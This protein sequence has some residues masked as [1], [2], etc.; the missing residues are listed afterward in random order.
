MKT[1]ITILF[2]G[3]IMVSC[4]QKDP[5]SVEAVIESGDLSAMKAKK[6]QVLKSYDSIA[7]VLGRLEKAITEKDTLKKYPLV[8]TFTL[9]DTLFQHFIDI[10]GNVETDQNL[11]IYPEYQGVLTRV[12]VNE[13]DKVSKG[14]TLARI[15]DG[16]LSNQLAQM[17]TQYD[18]AKTT[19]ERQERLWNQKIGSEIQY[20]QAKANMEAAKSSVDQMRA[21]V[22]RTTVRAPFSGTIDEIITEQG[23]VV[24]PGGQPLMRIVA[25]GDMYVKASVPEA[26]LGS[27]AKGTSV[28][29]TFPAINKVVEGQVKNVGN[30]INPNNRTFQ[31]EIDVP[32]KDKAI[33]PNLVA[34][35]EINDYSQENAQLIPANAIQENSKGDKYV[36]VLT[37]R[38]ADEA[39]AVR[40]QIETGKKYEGMVE[41]ISGLKPGETIVNEGALTL[42]D[43]SAV[44]IKETTNNLPNGTN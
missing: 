42:N 13:G 40:K 35:L 12:L 6:E 27:I 21:Q 1:T 14:Q 30:Y 37:E 33:K 11:L 23:T 15:D 34:K 28:K 10:Q 19:F 32:N 4:G 39:K 36:F 17:E 41:V 38:V 20:L 24:G 29:M 25:L 2:A 43:G 18:L 26:Y 16:G 44:K 9:K 7:Q 5:G 31:I 22:G 3:L 8:T